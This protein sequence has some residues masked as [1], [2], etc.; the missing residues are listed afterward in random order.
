MWSVSMKREKSNKV[1]SLNEELFHMAF[2]QAS[3]GMAITDPKGHFVRANRAYSTLTGYSESE[4][5]SRDLCGI[6]HPSDLLN[7]KQSA[8]KLRRGEID[9]FV[10]QQRYVKKGGAIV[11]VQN[12]VSGIHCTGGKTVNFIA[13]TENITEHKRAEDE[14]SLLATIVESSEDAI[15]GR[16]LDGTIISWNV[17][18]ERIFG[19]R[20]KEAIGRLYSF[21]VPKERLSELEEISL[22]VSPIRDAQGALLGFSTVG[23]DIAIRKRGEAERSRL[24]RQ[25]GER[26]KELSAMYDVAHL[27]QMEGKSTRTLLEEI[28]SLLPPTWQYSEVAAARVQLGEMEFKTPNFHSSRWSQRASFTTINGRKGIV[29]VVY[30]AARPAATEGPFSA[31]ERNLIDAVAEN[32]K[33]YLDR[34]YLESE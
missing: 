28:T 31:E 7:V 19:Y 33:V 30:L 9:S 1:P 20:A 29:E 10:I 27:L 15:I 6:S 3:V 17:G 4:L 25:L 18:A 16:K 5:W 22:T 26:I 32:L 11:W 8:A 24:V 13:L 14:R 21:L 12:T 34:K 2:A 23:R